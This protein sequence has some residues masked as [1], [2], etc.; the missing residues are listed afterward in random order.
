[1]I[2]HWSD[3][4]PDRAK[5]VQREW[6]DQRAHFAFLSKALPVGAYFTAIDVGSAGSARQGM[7]RKARGVRPGIADLLVVYRGTS[8]WIEVKSGSSLSPAQQLFRDAVTANGHLW[9]LARSTEDV[10]AALRSA[11]IPLRASLGDIRERIAEQNE[12]LPVKRRATR[13]PPG[14]GSSMSVAQYRR[15]HAKGLM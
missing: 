14:S 6:A 4:P 12:R 15:L 7:L 11:G 9:A 2:A 3:A 5:P 13:K 1:V 10:E 8:L